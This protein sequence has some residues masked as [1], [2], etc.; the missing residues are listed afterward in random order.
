MTAA[1]APLSAAVAPLNAAVA[2]VTV[3]VALAAVVAGAVQASADQQPALPG[4]LKLVAAVRE[5]VHPVAAA[6]AGQD[7]NR[8]AAGE[9]QHIL[10]VG[11]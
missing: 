4:C 2:P 6:D 9:T 10:E 3:G 11:C 7:A 1:V 8:N 5:P